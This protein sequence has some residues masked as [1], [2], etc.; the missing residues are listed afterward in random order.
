MNSNVENLRRSQNSRTPQGSASA[1]RTVT[2]YLGLM[3]VYIVA[4]RL[5]VSFASLPPGNITVIWLPAGVALV[6]LLLFGPRILPIIFLSSYLSNAPFLIDSLSATHLYHDMF[7]SLGPALTD[8][9]QPALAFYLYRRFVPEHPFSRGTSVIRFL[10]FSALLPCL[11][12]S[13]SIVLLLHLGGYTDGVV[14]SQLLLHGLVIVLGDTLGI[15]LVV[16]LYFGFRAPEQDAS[17]H[18]GHLTSLA[19]FVVSLILC[20]LAFLHLPQIRYMILPLLF[21]FALAAGLRGLSIALLT[22]SI[23]S[24][25]ATARGYGPFLET[26]APM[27]YTA[28]VSFLLCALPPF[29]Y[30]QATMHELRANR[31]LLNAKILARTTELEMANQRLREIANT[32]DLTGI[33][34][35]RCLMEVGEREVRRAARY[36]RPLSLLALD[37]DHFKNVNDTHGHAVGDEVLCGLTAYLGSLLRS[38]DRLGRMGGEEFDILLPETGD[39]EALRTA[40]K[41]RVAVATQNLE[42]SVGTLRVTISIGVA[43]LLPGEA[44]DQLLRRADQALYKAKQAGRNQVIALK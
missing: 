37:I 31:R 38:N 17:R 5:G 25:A 8:T 33:C 1:F 24:V 43:T 3:L 7:W 14:H 32:D 10:F 35:R 2:M 30:L 27:S 29:H 21:F 16:P 15:C 20:W 4:A 28:L 36:G 26:T 22:I 18:A 40:E 34:S 23:A 12:T 11:A 13:W 42:C 19:A 44:L 6:G 41:L 39:A 9:A